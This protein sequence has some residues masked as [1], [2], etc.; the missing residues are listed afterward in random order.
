MLGLLQV[1]EDLLGNLALSWPRTV[2]ARRMPNAPDAEIVANKSHCKTSMEMKCTPCEAAF[3]FSGDVVS[4]SLYSDTEST[5]LGPCGQ[6]RVLQVLQ[7][8][9]KLGVSENRGP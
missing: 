1:P 5:K 6:R 2:V 4:P 8:K 3:K 9:S 7:L